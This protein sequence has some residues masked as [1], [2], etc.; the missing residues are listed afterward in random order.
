MVWTATPSCRTAFKKASLPSSSGELYRYRPSSDDLA[1]LT[2]VGMATPPGEEVTDDHQVRPRRARR[3]FANCHRSEGVGGVGLE[4][5]AL[6]AGLLDGSSRALCGQLEAVDE[7]HAGLW[8]EST[9]ETDHAEAVAPVAEVPCAQLLA[10]ELIDIGVCLAVLAGLVAQL[11]E[12]RAACNLE[13]LGFGTGRLGLRPRRSRRPGPG[14]VR[15]PTGLS[16]Y[17][18]NRPSQPRSPRLGG[19]GR[20]CRPPG[21]PSM[22]HRR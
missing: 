13:Q 2:G 5:F 8:R 20:W 11:S 10:M 1:H 22:Q 3:P 7:R 15:P 9:C 17:R 6:A 14:T 21:G 12:V 19:P 16:G 18:G 4:A